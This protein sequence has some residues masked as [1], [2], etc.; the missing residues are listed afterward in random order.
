M[1]LII[2]NDNTAG[3]FCTAEHG[4]S[5][6]IETEKKF[7]FDVGPSDII[8]DNAKK[9]NIDLDP[10][11]DV[12]LSH[13]HW[14]HVNGLL[15]LKNKNIIC[16]PD[17]F[18][19]RFRKSNHSYIGMAEDKKQLSQRFTFNESTKPLQISES[20]WFL[21]EIPRK[22][23]FEAQTTPFELENHDNDFVPDDSGLVITT[24]KGL[25]VI[26][27]CAHSGICNMV[28]HAR[29]LFPQA[30]VYAVVG[31]F[32]LNSETEQ[33]E[34]TIAHFKTLN[35]SRVIPS[36]CTGLPALSQFYRHFSFMQVKTGN[37][38]VL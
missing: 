19:K 21:G 14:D 10:V 24:K 37:T 29:S 30:P 13:G 6:L 3:R 8:L 25:V 26:S 17:I 2:L 12:V 28:D 18:L 5:F 31:G 11:E 33:I 1:K 7:L 34:K 4:L 20:T 36:H 9:L 15:H 23:N 22:N 35:I 38:L 32:H 16:H 27:G